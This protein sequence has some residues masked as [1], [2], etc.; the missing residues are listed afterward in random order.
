M[1][2]PSSFCF[3]KRT[4]CHSV[5]GWFQMQMGIALHW[6]VCSVS[7]ANPPALLCVCKRAAVSFL[8]ERGVNVTITPDWLLTLSGLRLLATV[9]LRNHTAPCRSHFLRDVQC[10]GVDSQNPTE[11]KIKIQ[12]SITESLCIIIITLMVISDM[13]V[14]IML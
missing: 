6:S 13:S 5:Y 14:I 11:L 1:H 8:C 2:L 10:E 12:K 9:H 3:Y 7:L 4:C